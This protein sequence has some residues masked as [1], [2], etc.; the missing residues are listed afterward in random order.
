MAHE[1]MHYKYENRS[2]I[3]V[4]KNN[5]LGFEKS[6][7]IW[8][9]WETFFGRW[10]LIT[11]IFAALLMTYATKNER[12]RRK[13]NNYIGHYGLANVII[14]FGIPIFERFLSFF[15]F[16]E[17]YSEIFSSCVTYKTEAFTMSLP[18][19]FA[20]F[21][22]VDY[23]IAGCCRSL[24]IFCESLQNSIIFSIY[25]F[26]L[27]GYVTLK[28]TCFLKENILYSVLE[29]IICGPCV[30]LQVLLGIL[31]RRVDDRFSYYNDSN[32]QG[33]SYV[34]QFSNFIV[35]SWVL[36]LIVYVFF[37]F[38]NFESTPQDVSS[39]IKNI[40]LDILCYTPPIFAAF[41]LCNTQRSF[42]VGF[43]SAF[44]PIKKIYSLRQ[45]GGGHTFE[46]HL[47]PTQTCI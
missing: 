4:P 5:T 19:V 8:T 24:N 1:E 16:F 30:I 45:S 14:F 17:E 11:A 13:P 31:R 21:L 18:F 42:S 44:W 47:P 32:F 36:K 12:L 40:L 39:S 26:Y 23:T 7:S 15:N 27:T 10:I 46:M 6:L 9:I 28:M 37:G 20:F 35:Y 33:L 3:V 2:E 43:R 38:E 29:T 25:F 34:M 22:G 41:W